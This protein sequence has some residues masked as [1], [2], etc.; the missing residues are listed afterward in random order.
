ME[1]GDLREVGDLEGSF[2]IDIIWASFGFVAIVAVDV[3]HL[4]Q[5]R[6]A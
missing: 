6:P 1:I 4:Y 2:P 5:V 3:K